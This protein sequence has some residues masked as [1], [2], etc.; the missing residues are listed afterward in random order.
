MTDRIVHGWMA[1]GSEIVRY[2]RA[3]KWYVEP[4]PASGRKRWQVTCADAARL[5]VLGKARLGR[6]GGSAFD[7]VVQRLRAESGGSE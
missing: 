4:A 1:D 6:Y 3:G 7:R 5:A 2:D